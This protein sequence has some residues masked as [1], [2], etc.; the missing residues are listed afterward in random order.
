MK[1]IISSVKIKVDEAAQLL[2]LYIFI[3]KRDIFMLETNKKN[4]TLH[5]TLIGANL[6][7][8]TDVNKASKYKHITFCCIPNFRSKYI[9][10][11]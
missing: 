4:L 7:S 11:I 9:N 3:F 5:Y 2:E 8:I 1:N 6:D 10:Y